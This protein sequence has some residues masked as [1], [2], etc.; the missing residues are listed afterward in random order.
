MAGLYSSLFYDNTALAM[1]NV[2]HCLAFIYWSGSQRHPVVESKYA[3]Y[4]RVIV[5][6]ASL[7]F[8]PYKWKQENTSGERYF[9]WIEFIGGIDVKPALALEIFWNGE[10]GENTK[11]WQSPITALLPQIISSD[12]LHE[13]PLREANLRSRISTL[14]ADLCTHVY[15]M[16]VRYL[17]HLWAVFHQTV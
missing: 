15:L 12:L 5:R 3:M 14:D 4:I 2:G 6:C 17:G 8:F 13:P 11:K 9:G 1:G 7:P 10:A 16:T